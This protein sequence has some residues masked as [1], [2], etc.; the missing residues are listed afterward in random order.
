MAVV[1]ALLAALAY[2]MSDFA[3]GLASRRFAAEPVAGAAQILGLLTAGSPCSCF[4]GSA[5]EQRRSAGGRL[6]G[7]AAHWAC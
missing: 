1:L 6:A 4:P 7:L 3:A 5:R 2:G